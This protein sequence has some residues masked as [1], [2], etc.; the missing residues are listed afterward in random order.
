MF[1]D[2]AKCIVFMSLIQTAIAQPGVSFRA[3]EEA[4]LSVDSMKVTLAL[5]SEQASIV[6]TINDRYSP[7]FDSVRMSNVNR[8]EKFAMTRRLKGERDNELKLLLSEKQYRT[9]QAGQERQ[10]ESDP[11]IPETHLLGN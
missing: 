5:T 1:R 9:Y 3:L 4:N 6:T 2:L 7:R 8:Y 10:R 11:G